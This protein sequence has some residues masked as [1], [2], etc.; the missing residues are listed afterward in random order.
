MKNN[1][2]GKIVLV[3]GNKINYHIA[4]LINRPDLETEQEAPRTSSGGN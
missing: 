1:V 4:D 3:I 2:T